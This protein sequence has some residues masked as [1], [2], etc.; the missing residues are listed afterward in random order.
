MPVIISRTA[1]EGQISQ[2]AQVPMNDYLF[3][4]HNDVTDDSR[5]RDNDWA[6]YISKLQQAGV[7]QGGSAIGDGVCM[8]KNG[9]PPRIT[10][11]LSGF[12]RVQA[13]SLS[14]AQQLVQGNPVFEAGGTVEIRELPKT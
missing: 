9:T 6:A 4:M 8:T 2:A 10:T 11:Q 7:F 13:E 14:K 12:I 1:I 5:S 3:L